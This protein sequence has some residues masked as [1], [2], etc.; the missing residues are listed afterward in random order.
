MRASYY[1]A[2]ADP[3][4]CIVWI[5]DMDEECVVAEVNALYPGFR[6]IYRDTEGQWDELLHEGGK[7]HGFAP[8]RDMPAPDDGMQS[9]RRNA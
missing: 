2:G 7:F 8:A 6:I 5:V 9:P 1:I 4:R 3:N